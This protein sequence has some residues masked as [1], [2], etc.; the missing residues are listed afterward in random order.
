MTYNWYNIFNLTEFLD[1]DLV[2]RE[3]EITLQG[4]G[5]KTILITKGIN[6][7][8]L[9]DDVFLSLNLNDQNPFEFY[10]HAIYVDSND[11]VWLGTPT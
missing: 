8:M 9:Y 1:A 10:D 3:V 2:S 4:L 5:L 11:D 7:S 6:V